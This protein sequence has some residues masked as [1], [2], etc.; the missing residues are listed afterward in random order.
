MRRTK[1]SGSSKR[2]NV[3]RLSYGVEVSDRTLYAIERGEQ[4]P[5]LDFYLAAIAALEAE[6][7]YFAPALRADVASRL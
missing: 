4:M 3:T 5:R 7:D 1:R 2:P 6:R